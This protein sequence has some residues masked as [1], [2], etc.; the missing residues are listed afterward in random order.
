MNFREKYILKIETKI[1]VEKALKIIKMNSKRGKNETF[2]NVLA[3][4]RKQ[5]GSELP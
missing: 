3:N 2:E 1:L 4:M 5:S